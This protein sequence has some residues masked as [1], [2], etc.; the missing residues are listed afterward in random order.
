MDKSC[1]ARLNGRVIMITW[2]MSRIQVALNG[3]PAR[4]TKHYDGSGPCAS[5]SGCNATG[6][7]GPR[8]HPGLVPSGMRY[9]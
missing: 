1:R 9:L 4:G 7:A 5:Y 8:S 3:F 6:V 2:G